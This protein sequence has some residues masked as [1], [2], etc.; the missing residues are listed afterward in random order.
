M[1]VRCHWPPP[2][3]SLKWGLNQQDYSFHKLSKS[4]IFTWLNLNVVDYVDT[5]VHYNY[6][7]YKTPILLASCLLA[8]LHQRLA[9]K[10][11]GSYY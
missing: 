8:S 9:N 10:S 5:C 4:L 2:P 3:R 1:K 7:E 11:C 6:K